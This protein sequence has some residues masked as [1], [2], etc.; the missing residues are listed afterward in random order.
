MR[1]AVEYGG[2][3]LDFE[4]PDDRLVG[5][6]Q[7]PEAVAGPEV[8]PLLRAVLEGPLEFP[9]LRRSFVPGDRV[10]VAV[11][12]ET[13]EIVS[14]LGAIFEALREAEVTADAI[15]VLAAG[16]APLDEAR[17]AL[18]IP[19]LSWTAH[20]P[21]DREKLAYL[22]ST[23]AGRR[24]YL[25]RALTD[26]DAVVPVGRIGFDPVL[27]Y[28]GPWSV[29]FPG[30]GDL[31]TQRAYRALATD[32]PPDPDR[33]RPTLAESAEV[34]WLLGC[35]FHVGLVPGA[36]GLSRVVAGL[37]S[38]V[39]REGIRAVDALWSYRAERRAE[40][41]VVGLG[42]PGVPT[43]IDDLAAALANA[44]RLVRRGGKIVALSR[45]EGPIGPALQRLAGSD[46]RR[47][48]TTALKGAEGEPDYPAARQIARALAWADVYL[49]GGLDDEIVDDLEMVS[50]GR[51]EEARRLV[52]SS[53][54]CIVLSQ[55][56][57]A[58]AEA[59]DEIDDIDTEE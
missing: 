30:L 1:V 39:R 8:G 20:D 32:V 21:E 47:S 26:A 44:R 22:A 28:R 16:P 9:P 36:A 55:A 2:E 19:G 57:R 3:R 37:E 27:G 34:S 54:S 29:I 25:H 48:V 15:E 24:I 14:V 13:P 59:A 12:P 45:V 51:P 11:D 53:D 46:L 56:D 58:R 35:Q 43:R 7:G 23:T 5:C 41:V 38:A 42:R 10:V 40:L 4:V 31:E 17:E 18:E 33:D 6:W 50:L 49:F 52:D